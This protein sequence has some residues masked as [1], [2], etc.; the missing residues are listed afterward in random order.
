MKIL[1]Q[2]VNTILQQYDIEGLLEAGAPLDEYASEAE[3]IYS[4]IIILDEKNRNINSVV[5]IVS[6][7]WAK[8]FN[9]IQD[10][11]DK[12]LADIQ[13]VA[14]DILKNIK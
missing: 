13:N 7:V 9:L 10:D 3:D 1:S 14:S 5:S 11:L 6:Y 8:S 12:R 4:A 2:Q